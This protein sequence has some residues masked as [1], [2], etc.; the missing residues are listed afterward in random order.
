MYSYYSL[1]SQTLT[2][3]RESDPRDYTVIACLLN[4]SHDTLSLPDQ[5]KPYWL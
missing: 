1:A 3:A 2:L 5:E 4:L